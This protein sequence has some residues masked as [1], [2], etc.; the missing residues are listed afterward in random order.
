MGK[1]IPVWSEVLK[2]A[3]CAEAYIVE[4]RYSYLEDLRDCL[5][6]DLQFLKAL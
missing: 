4:R 6:Q 2:K 1:G 5:A 3:N